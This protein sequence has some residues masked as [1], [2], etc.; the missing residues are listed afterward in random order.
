MP[1]MEAR[2]EKEEARQATVARALPLGGGGTGPQCHGK[3]PSWWWYR[4][5][6][7]RGGHCSPLVVIGF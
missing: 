5:T 7:Y 6:M 4:A 3:S 2:D 1:G